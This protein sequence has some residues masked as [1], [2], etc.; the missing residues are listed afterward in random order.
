MVVTRS[1]VLDQPHTLLC[2]DARVTARHRAVVDVKI[3]FG[4]TAEDK[5]LVVALTLERGPLGR[6]DV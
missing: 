1:E 4:G 3:R 5:R 2:D 6:L